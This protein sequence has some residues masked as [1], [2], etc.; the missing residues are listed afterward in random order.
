MMDSETNA[1]AEAES[2]RAETQY[3]SDDEDYDMVLRSISDA[4][5][6]V[7]KGVSAIEDDN[8]NHEMR[9]GMMDL[10]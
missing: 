4:N 2:S 1:A 10:S 9:D 8:S 3:G 5:E 7:R 6:G